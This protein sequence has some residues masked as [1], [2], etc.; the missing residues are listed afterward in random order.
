M[1]V[2]QET[3]RVG[4]AGVGTVGRV[5]AKHLRDIP[6][7][8]L[9]AVS[10]GDEARAREYLESIGYPD[11]LSVVDLEELADHVD[12]VVE[13]TLPALFTRVAGST[14]EAG[15]TLVTINSGALLSSWDL[16]DRAK[17][18][19]G[20]IVL[21]SGALLALDA[22]QAAA[23]G[24]IYSI[25]MTTRK[26][27]D[28]L[29]KTPLVEEKGLDLEELSEPLLLFEG[30]VREAIVGFPSNLNVAV[31]LSLAGVGPDKTTIEV[32]ADP[33]LDR[34]THRI[35]VDSD[36]ASLDFSIAN[37]ISD[38][39]TSHAGK[40]TALSMVAALQKMVSPLV[41]GT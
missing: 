14:V 9:A 36:S 19:G 16:V 21:P 29:Q 35:V 8:E 33:A 41:V 37:I 5:V 30:T 2:Q 17:E 26:P 10:V 12:V 27:P 28:S 1:N 20:K 23:L 38:N 3:I 11:S 15:R 24:E 25:H 13:C 6:E 31:A 18:T 7:Y 39:Y 22:V 32:W 34:N 4:I 40:I